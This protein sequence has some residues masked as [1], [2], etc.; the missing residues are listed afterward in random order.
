M[1]HLLQLFIANASNHTSVTNLI[2]APLIGATVIGFAN[3]FFSGFVNLRRNAL[4]V[5]ALSHTLLAETLAS[6]RV[7]LSQFSTLQHLLQES[8][9]FLIYQ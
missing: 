9:C 5:S 2:I 7:Q 4:S 1:F 8:H 6:Q 3:G